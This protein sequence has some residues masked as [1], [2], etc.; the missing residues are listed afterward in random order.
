[1]R[2]SLGQG[3]VSSSQTWMRSA[4][5]FRVQRARTNSRLQSW[6]LRRRL[7]SYQSLHSL[8]NIYSN[9]ICQACCN[10]RKLF[11]RGHVDHHTRYSTRSNCDAR[12]ASANNDDDQKA[13]VA[14]PLQCVSNP[15]G[16]V[17]A[18]RREA[19]ASCHAS[20][21]GELLGR[22]LG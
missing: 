8:A 2:E 15:G 22:S 13:G 6:R 20:T 10:H 11:G 9:C 1:V 18:K 7:T 16:C 14:V 5:T 17:R 19:I 4:Q 21:A 12:H 3:V